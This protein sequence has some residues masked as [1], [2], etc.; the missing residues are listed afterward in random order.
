MWEQRL[1]PVRLTWG[2]VERSFALCNICPVAL[3][4]QKRIGSSDGSGGSSPFPPALQSSSISP[5]PELPF[6]PCLPLKILPIHSAPFSHQL[7]SALSLPSLPQTQTHPPTPPA[8]LFQL[9]SLEGHSA[10]PVLCFSVPSLHPSLLVC[11]LGPH[12]PLWQTVTPQDLLWCFP[13]LPTPSHSCLLQKHHSGS[14]GRTSFLPAAHT[15][16]SLRLWVAPR[17]PLPPLQAVAVAGLPLTA[18]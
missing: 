16:A 11:C 15:E 12:L 1:S 9:P 8:L 14:A 4:W 5:V 10:I 2:D 13:Q 17:S 18:T 3:R 7:P 6:P